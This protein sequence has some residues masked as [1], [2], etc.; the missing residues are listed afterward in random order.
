MSTWRAMQ[1]AANRWWRRHDEA[2]SAPAANG[3]PRESSGTLSSK[4]LIKWPACKQKVRGV[5]GVCKWQNRKPLHYAQMLE[6]ECRCCR[7][8]GYPT[9]QKKELAHLRYGSSRTDM[10]IPE[11]RGSICNM[12]SKADASFSQH[13]C[14]ECPVAKDIVDAE[15]AAGAIIAVHPNR[16]VWC[17]AD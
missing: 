14:S 9:N 2:S 11:Y 16:K 3:P 6:C 7:S 8:C 1:Y 12:V 15:R 10:H 13:S 4:L 17:M 5:R